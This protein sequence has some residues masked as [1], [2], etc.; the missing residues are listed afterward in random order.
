MVFIFFVLH[1][2]T[3]K[4]IFIDKLAV[5]IQP[6]P[7][8]GNNTCSRAVTLSR[9]VCPCFYI[10]FLTWLY[11]I[12][13][14]PTSTIDCNNFKNL[15][16]T[17]MERVS[18]SQESPQLPVTKSDIISASSQPLLLLLLSASIVLP[19]GSR[20]MPSTD[21]AS[22]PNL[23]FVGMASPHLRQL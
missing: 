9:P 11:Q 6:S 22:T 4:A 16:Q 17:R 14:I 1:K 23:S 12:A 2:D 10:L 19:G 5:L 20:C 13:S 8:V 21:P 7:S 18:P 3:G 15:L